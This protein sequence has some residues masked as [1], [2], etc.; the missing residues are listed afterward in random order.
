M[1]W[2]DQTLDELTQSASG[3]AIGYLRGATPAAEPTALAA[4]ALL[5]HGR[6][7]PARELAD[8]L[9][10]M[11]QANGEVAVGAGEDRPGW[12]TS[13]TITAWSVINRD[14][15]GD[16]IHRALSWLLDNRGKAVERS[17][18]FGHNTQLVG[19]A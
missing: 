4:L 10:T 1:T 19:W 16:H 13:L 2:L 11:Q 12:P 14:T 9:A 7:E 15:F 18:S 3:G 17:D 6:F 8:A 5:A